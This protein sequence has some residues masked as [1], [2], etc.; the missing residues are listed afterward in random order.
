MELIRKMV[1]A[2]EDAP[3]GFAPRNLTV[4]G[5]TPDQVGYHGYLMLDAGL[6]EG[7][8]VS[9]MGSS[10]PEATLRNL[11]WAGHEFAD[12]ARD[13][14]RWKKPWASFKRKAAR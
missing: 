9:H 7:S 11:T 1:L 5:Y 8:K 3:T 6:A 10:S 12:A 13:E 4:D 2:I 14:T